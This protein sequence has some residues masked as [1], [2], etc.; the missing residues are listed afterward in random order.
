MATEIYS[1]RFDSDY[2]AGLKDEAKRT[3]QDTSTYIK[4]LIDFARLHADPAE[5]MGIL[6]SAID[7]LTDT[8]ERGVD[9]NFNGEPAATGSGMTGMLADTLLEAAVFNRVAITALIKALVPTE[10]TGVLNAFDARMSK[11]RVAIAASN[12]ASAGGI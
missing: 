9:F 7:G 6:L 3:G 1:I 10:H 11:V 4:G 12:V 8:L 5:D 2:L